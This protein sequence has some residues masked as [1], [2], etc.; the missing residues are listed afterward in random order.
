MSEKQTLPSPLE[1][2]WQGQYSCPAHIDTGPYKWQSVDTRNSQNRERTD[3][4]TPSVYKR[5]GFKKESRSTQAP[6]VPTNTNTKLRSIINHDALGTE[7]FPYSRP[8]E[9]STIYSSP[10]DRNPGAE[11]SQCDRDHDQAVAERLP[12][13]PKRFRYNPGL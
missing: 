13:R 8:R 1:P 2:E 3:S 4:T 7:S 11:L 9:V 6:Y 10:G 12:A 5:H